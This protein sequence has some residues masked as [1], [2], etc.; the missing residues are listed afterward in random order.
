MT[1]DEMTRDGELS[2]QLRQLNANGAFRTMLDALKWDISPAHDAPGEETHH[3]LIQLGRI[4]GWNAC[5]D[6]IEALTVKTG[7]KNK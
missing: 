5:I 2:H 4:L 7:A 3:A 6:T 1:F